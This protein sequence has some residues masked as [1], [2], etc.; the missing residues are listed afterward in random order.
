MITTQD[1]WTAIDRG[2]EKIADLEY[3]TSVRSRVSGDIDLYDKNMVLSIE[4]YANISVLKK[5]HLGLSIAQDKKIA[6]LY[7]RIKTLTQEF[8][9]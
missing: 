6:L 5:M 9:S 2:R 8:K 1:V 3:Y 4:I 7:E